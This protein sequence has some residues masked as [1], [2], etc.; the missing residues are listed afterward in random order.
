MN[1][2]LEY[3]VLKFK[4]WKDHWIHLYQCTDN[5]WGIVIYE[6]DDETLVFSTVEFSYISA[7]HRFNDIKENI[8]NYL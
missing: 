4:H 6:D 8:T 1:L 3:K 5:M 7:L 2:D